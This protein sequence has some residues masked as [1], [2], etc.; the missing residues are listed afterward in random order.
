MAA[1]AAG[2]SVS[3][4]APLFDDG[5]LSDEQIQTLLQE[6][7]DRLR[8]NESSQPSPLTIPKFNADTT[9]KPCINI[10]ED[11][12]RVDPLYL[13]KQRDQRFVE[14]IRTVAPRSSRKERLLH[15]C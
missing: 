15:V 9:I 5:I 6:A 2:D 10:T 13:R 3:L 8:Q 1:H 12:A 14:R 4:D 11:A 7:E